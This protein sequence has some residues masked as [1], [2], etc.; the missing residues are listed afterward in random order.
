MRSKRRIIRNECTQFPDLNSGDLLLRQVLLFITIVQR[1]TSQNSRSLPSF[2]KPF[3]LFIKD[4]MKQSSIL[5]GGESDGI[6]GR[7]SSLLRDWNQFLA[8]CRRQ[9]DFC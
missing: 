6:K 2:G 9:K 3:R 8:Y 5:F 7:D 1:K 4:L